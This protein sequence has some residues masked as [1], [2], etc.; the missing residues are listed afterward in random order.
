MIPIFQKSIHLP[1]AISNCKPASPTLS[2]QPPEN[3]P[4]FSSG[5][6]NM[7]NRTHTSGHSHLYSWVHVKIIRNGVASA[8]ESTLFFVMRT[9]AALWIPYSLTKTQHPESP[10]REKGPWEQMIA[11]LALSGHHPTTGASYSSQYHIGFLWYI[12]SFPPLHRDTNHRFPQ[13]WVLRKNSSHICIVIM[14]LAILYTAVVLRYIG[15]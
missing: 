6:Q 13:W 10:L 8:K 5:M 14:K 4:S 7:F 9:P 3:E 15:K 11:I 2:T 1:R 12:Q